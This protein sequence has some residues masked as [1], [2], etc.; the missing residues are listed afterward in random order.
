[1]SSG[2]LVGV[3]VFVQFFFNKLSSFWVSAPFSSGA[4]NTSVILM[5]FKKKTEG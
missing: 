5:L 1:M 2:A 3:K 4:M